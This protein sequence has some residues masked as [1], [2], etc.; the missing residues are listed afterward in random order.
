MRQV[1]LG[2]EIQFEHSFSDTEG[3][4][5]DPSDV[6]LKIVKNASQLVAGPYVY[7]EGQIFRASEGAYYHTF[8]VPY[9]TT[10]GNFTARWEGDDHVGLE[11]FQVIDPPLEPGT[12]IDP[13]SIKGNIRVS[14]LYQ[15]MGTG[16]TDRLFLVGHASGLEINEPYQV[17]NIQEAVNIIGGNSESPMVRA[18]L[19]AYNTGARD[20]WLLAA[21]PENEY[22]PFDFNDVE[23]R[24]TPRPEWGGLNFYER[25]AERLETTYAQLVQYD[26]PEIV[27]PIEA[28]F[29]D[30]RGVD[31]LTPLVNHCLESFENVSAPR[32]GIIGTRIVGR[33]SEDIDIMA[34]DSRLG[35]FDVAG[36]FCLVAVGEGVFN[37][38][39]MPFSH[40]SPVAVAA[41]ATLARSSLAQGLTYQLLNTVVSVY[42]PEF[43]DAEIKTLAQARLNPIVRKQR[44]KRGFAYNSVLACDNTLTPEGSDYWSV[45]QMRLVSK[46]IQD[47]R[48]LGMRAMGTIDFVQFKSAVGDY[49]QGLLHSDVIRDY[50]LLI[51]RDPFVQNKAT[52]DVNLKPYFGVRELLFQVEVGPGA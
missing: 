35:N 12:L 36:K 15:R 33:T 20:I 28:P 43:T 30:T 14:A 27:V 48:T 17:N 25:Y 26:Y 21:A 47:I 8:E 7:S 45:V 16:E 40:T 6:T 32:I 44:G 10:P 19:E 1:V 50:N 31:F 39:Q 42:G 52:V 11:D 24:F 38:P 34:S 2:Q 9:F 4:Y 41:A 3:D 22:V 18:L 37:L 51:E 29:Y 23:N 5:F 46:V 13:P 49:L